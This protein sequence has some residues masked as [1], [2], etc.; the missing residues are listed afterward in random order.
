[1]ACTHS[2]ASPASTFGV[3]GV[4]GPSSKV[5]TT[6]WSSSGS[7]CGKTLIPTLGVVAAAAARKGEVASAG[8]RG[9]GAACAD[10]IHAN[11]ASASP[12]TRIGV[13]IDFGRFIFVIALGVALWG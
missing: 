9:A 10:A 3:V 6:S 5:S 7:V 12:S 8:L 4:H 13:E 1:G 2:W 11:E